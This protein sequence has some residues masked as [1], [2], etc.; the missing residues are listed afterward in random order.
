MTQGLLRVLGRIPLEQFWPRGESDA[1]TTKVK[2]EV[3]AGAFR[4]RPHPSAQFRITKAFNKA[5][6]RGRVSREIIDKKGRVTIRL[7]GVDAPELHYMP[8]AA[9]KPKDQTAT[10]RKIFLQWNHQYRQHF[11]ESATVALKTLLGQGDA[12]SIACTVVTAVDQPDDAVDTYGRLVG[13]ILVTLKGKT[14]ILNQWLMTQGWTVPAFYNSMSADEIRTLLALGEEARRK[15]RGCWP[16]VMKSVGTL[17]FKLRYRESAP[18][19]DKDDQGP[20]LMPKLFRRLSTFAVNKKAAMVSGSFTQYVKDKN[21]QYYE[22]DN[23]LSQGPTAAQPRNLSE[24]IGADGILL[25]QPQD[26]VFHEA[27]AELLGPNN[28]PPKW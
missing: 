14:V 27:E 18:P 8:Q 5:R 6:V 26:L 25:E 1:D 13:D 19:G 23:F 12:D 15:G 2:V 24:I 17:D 22:I 3:A 4:F 21:D 16:K 10:E 28:K 11:A 20:V 9:K 7:Q